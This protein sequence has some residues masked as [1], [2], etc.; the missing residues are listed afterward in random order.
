M[1][2][3]FRVTR[4]VEFSDTDMAGIMHFSGF[5]RF[6]ETVE[7]AFIRSLGLSVWPRPGAPEVGWPRVHA[8]CDYRHPLRFEDEVELE[9]LVREKRPRTLT[10]EIRFHRLNAPAVR[11]AAR[12]VLTV[13]CVRR[14][15]DGTMK[16]API[17]PE[18]ADRIEPAAPGRLAEAPFTAG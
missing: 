18:F 3:E 15:P 5:F 12:G 2:S 11:D 4:R 17:P 14:Q 13:V 1:P 6:M 8:A 10:Y 7:H 16:A 9:L